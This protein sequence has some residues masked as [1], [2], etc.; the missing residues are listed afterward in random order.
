MTVTEP[1]PAI[2]DGAGGV[3]GAAI[4]GLTA[5]DGIDAS[6]SPAAFFAVAVNV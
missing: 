2:A 3:P 6:D 5:A 1:S 4:D